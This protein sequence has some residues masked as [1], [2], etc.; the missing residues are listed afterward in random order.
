MVD[1]S[2]NFFSIYQR[3]LVILRPKIRPSRAAISLGPPDGV[4]FCGNSIDICPFAQVTSCI[5]VS[6]AQIASRLGFMIRKIQFWA[7]KAF[8]KL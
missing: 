3:I 7:P 6:I 8:Y 4:P 1:F 2:L 5:G